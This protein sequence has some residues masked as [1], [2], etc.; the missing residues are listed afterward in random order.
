M[1]TTNPTNTPKASGCGCGPSGSACTTARR[2]AFRP[3][4]DIAEGEGEFV[5]VA[6]VPGATAE[7]LDLTVDQ[8]VLTLRAP[9]AARSQAGACLVA[10]YGVGDYERSFRLG[11]DIDVAKISA[12]LK[13]GVLTLRLPKAESA[14]P[15]KIS[16][17][18]A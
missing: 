1:T 6:D 11:E 15:R 9:V 17:R 18:A 16:I 13:D 7:T 12:E 3:A 5:I 10:E 4:V 8:G 14:K 2:A